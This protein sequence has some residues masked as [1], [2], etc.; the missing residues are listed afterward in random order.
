VEDI[1]GEAEEME[2]LEAAP[3]PA[4]PVD[5]GAKRKSAL[6]ESVLMD[7]FQVSEAMAEPADEEL[8]PVA[9]VSP[10]PAAPAAANLGASMMQEMVSIMR[11]SMRD[12]YAMLARRVE[13]FRGI[14]PEDVARLFAKGATVEYEKGSIVFEKGDTSRELYIILGGAVDIVDGERVL[15]TLNRGGM[16]GEMALV[17]SEPRSATAI[18]TEITSVL[19]LSEEI[20]RRVLTKE[21]AVQLLLNM[22]ITLSQRLRIAN[23]S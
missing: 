12:T 13:L 19:V 20:I 7:A 15:A 8:S 5:E 14:S 10:A 1:F 17:S 16:F 2:S 6:E 9:T 22:L 4:K 23:R 3:P 18:A 11:D 21:A